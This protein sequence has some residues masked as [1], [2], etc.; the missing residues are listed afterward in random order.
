MTTRLFT[1]LSAALALLVLG[2]AACG[3]GDGGGG[4]T[5]TAD[6]SSTVGP[7]VTK[8]A[9]DFKD[10]EGVDVTVGISGT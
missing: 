6:G 10:A 1:I 7:F 4:S 9:E 5:I 2:A 3:G 8:A